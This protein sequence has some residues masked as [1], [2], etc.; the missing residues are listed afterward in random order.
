MVEVRPNG[1][2]IELTTSLI[3]LLLY[4]GHF[5]RIVFTLAFDEWQFEHCTTVVIS[6]ASFRRRDFNAETTS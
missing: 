2:G 1:M 6:H 4:L 3:P 5:F